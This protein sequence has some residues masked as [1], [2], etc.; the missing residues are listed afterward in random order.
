MNKQLLLLIT[1]LFISISLCFAQHAPGIPLKALDHRNPENDNS[2]LFDLTV[3]TGMLFGEMQEYVYYDNYNDGNINYML[4]RLDWDIMPSVYAGLTASMRIA[5]R[6]YMG[7]GAWFGFPMRSGY[8]EDRDWDLPNEN[9]PFNGELGRISTHDNFIEHTVFADI[10]AGYGVIEEVGMI[11]SLS[12]GFTY[13]RF[14]FSG[15]NGSFLDYDGVSPPSGTYPEMTV[16]TYEQNWFIAYLGGE[17]MAALTDILSIRL[18]VTASPFMS[19]VFGRDRH[20][21]N[22]EEFHDYPQFGFRTSGSA[23]LQVDL[24]DSVLLSVNGI[25]NYAP[26]LQGIS[27]D[28]PIG[29]DSFIPSYGINGGA[30]ELTFGFSF[31]GTIRLF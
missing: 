22:N 4:S 18:C 20:I 7:F 24:L 31:S 10:N 15:K 29:S 11:L 12:L 27:F 3:D 21:T 23:A 6:W 16:I 30:S 19:F 13:R 28:G 14:S 9:P 2:F 1:T 26:S 5:P 25:I 8:M 17:F